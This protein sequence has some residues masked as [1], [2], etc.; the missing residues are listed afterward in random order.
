MD[1]E[2]NGEKSGG[3]DESPGDGGI[4][5]TRRAAVHRLQRGSNDPLRRSQASSLFDFDLSFVGE[6]F[7]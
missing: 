2:E 4:V 7:F 5:E 1:P 3:D 6:L